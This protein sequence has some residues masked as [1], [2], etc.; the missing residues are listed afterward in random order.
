[1]ASK[2]W[3]FLLI[4]HIQINHILSECLK[5]PQAITHEIQNEG[6]IQWKEISFNTYAATFVFDVS[7]KIWNP[8]ID[9][10]LNAQ[11]TTRLFND[12]FPSQTWRFKRGKQ[13]QQ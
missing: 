3:Q 13:H 1:M 2:L 7:T 6:D 9:S 12:S 8:S 10:I 4:C 11:I 5:S